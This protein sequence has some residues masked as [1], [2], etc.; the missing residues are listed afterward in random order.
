[1]FAGVRVALYVGVWGE[2]AAVCSR[3]CVTH[4][5]CVECVKCVRGSVCGLYVGSVG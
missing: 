2:C 5:V 4:T 1:M 3:E